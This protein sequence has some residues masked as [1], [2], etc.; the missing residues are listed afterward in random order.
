[1]TWITMTS[2]TSREASSHSPAIR[3]PFFAICSV[4]VSRESGVALQR[5]EFWNETTGQRHHRSIQEVINHR[6]AICT[7][8]LLARLPERARS[9]R[10]PDARRPR[11]SLANV[12]RRREDR[13]RELA[14]SAPR[15]EVMLEIL[16]H[17]DRTYGGTAGYLREAGVTTDE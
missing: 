7:P 11:D 3:S 1:M 2:G 12:R 14:R 16:Q 13:E 10:L 4:G 8:P 6:D 15:A 5:L 17:L 9:W